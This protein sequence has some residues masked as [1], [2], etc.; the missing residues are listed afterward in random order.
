MR[1]SP[2]AAG[3]VVAGLF[4]GGHADGQ[5]LDHEDTSVRWGR[6]SWLLL[7]ES[8]HSVMKVGQYY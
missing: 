5:L 1:V 2:A 3:D 8:W 6:C 4:S 7:W